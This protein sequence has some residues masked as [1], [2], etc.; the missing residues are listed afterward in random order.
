[1][2]AQSMSRD[3]TIL[4][5]ALGS[6][7]ADANPVPGSVRYL[8]RKF[9]VL[10]AYLINAAGIAASPTDKAVVNLL[11][12]DGATVASHDTNV[13]AL[14]ANV[15]VEMTLVAAKLDLAVGAI[16]VQYDETDSG[17]AVALTSSMVQVVGYWIQTEG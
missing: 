5:I 2:S 10:K 4:E 3:L 8:P 14:T 16:K 7:S 6:P 17:T 13:G 15:P 12:K 1:M 11:D 9:R